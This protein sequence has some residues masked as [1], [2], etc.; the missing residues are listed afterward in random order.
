[1]VKK[2]RPHFF[3]L[4]LLPAGGRW[5][6]PGEGAPTFPLSGRTSIVG[7]LLVV[8]MS[9]YP[10]L[11]RLWLEFPQEVKAANQTGG[12]YQCDYSTGRCEAIL[13]GHRPLHT[14][15][16]QAF[17]PGVCGGWPMGQLLCL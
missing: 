15:T 1:M 5:G 11:S 17:S 10:F 6:I 4:S 2:E 12:L 8:L 9:S 7:L 14:W 16:C 3:L 13:Q